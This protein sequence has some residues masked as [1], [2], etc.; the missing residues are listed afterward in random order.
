[1]YRSVSWPLAKRLQ[2]EAEFPV[3]G[4]NRIVARTDDVIGRVLAVSGV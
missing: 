3:A 2:L 1:L 4:G